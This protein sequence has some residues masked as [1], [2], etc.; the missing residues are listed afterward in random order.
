MTY[1]EIVTIYSDIHTQHVNAVCLQNVLGLNVK[2]GG[3]YS[4]HRALKREHEI[5]SLFG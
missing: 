4:N 5:H 3:T 1:R 2:R